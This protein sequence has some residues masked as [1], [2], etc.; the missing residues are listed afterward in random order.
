MMRKTQSQK[1][2]PV[3]TSSCESQCGQKGLSVCFNTYTVQTGWLTIFEHYSSAVGGN[4]MEWKEM[5]ADEN[6]T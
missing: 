1:H 4:R 3:G 5:Q 6:K 2:K